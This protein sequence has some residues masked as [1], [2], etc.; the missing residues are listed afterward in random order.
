ME[1]EEE[2]EDEMEEEEEEEEDDEKEQEEEMAGTAA[3]REQARGLALG[4]D[5]EKAA[6]GRMVMAVAAVAKKPLSEGKKFLILEVICMDSETGVD[7]EVPYV[8][9][10]IK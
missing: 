8:R 3:I 7:V 9:L 5:A 6:G 10:R 4:E 1:E 2:E